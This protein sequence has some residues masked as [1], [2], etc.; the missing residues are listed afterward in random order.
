[1]M[2]V[3]NENV[4]EASERRKAAQVLAHRAKSSRRSFA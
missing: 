3:N 1:M 2:E 4:A